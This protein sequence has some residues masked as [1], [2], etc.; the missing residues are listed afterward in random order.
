MTETAPVTESQAAA[1]EVLK[2]A[3]VRE[4]VDALF[5]AV[6]GAGTD[7]AKTT[8]DS[9]TDT[10]PLPADLLESLYANNALAQLIVDSLPDDSLREGFLLKREDSTPDADKDDAEAILKEWSRLQANESRFARGA[11]WGR[12]FGGGGLIL[13]VRGAGDL[14]TPLDDADVTEIEWVKDF[15]RQQVTLLETT[16]TGEP[17]KFQYRPTAHNSS[18]PAV[19]VHASRIIFFPGATTTTQGRIRNQGWDYSVLQAC[20]APLLSYESMWANIDAMLSDSS[21]A[22]F[23]ISGLIQALA[24]DGGQGSV[25]TRLQLMDMSRSNYKAV[26][27]DAGDRQGNGREDFDVVERAG[28]GGLDKVQ[29]N[30][31][32]RVAAAAKTPE[33]ILL[34]TAPGG[35]SATGDLERA[36]HYGR[37]DAYRR[38]VLTPRAQRIVHLIART[39]GQAKPETWEIVWPELEK[40][41]PVDTST[42]V[43]M[44]VDAAVALI[45]AQ[46]LLPEEVALSLARILPDLPITID[47]ASRREALSLGLE[48]LAAR[49]LSEVEGQVPGETTSGRKAAASTSGGSVQG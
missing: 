13:G 19:E 10:P 12:L 34:G 7:R 29:Q 21:Q 9:W 41:S 28:L 31:F 2:R 8:Y 27:L 37:C 24:E 22:V 38:T 17:V 44:A 45:G 4:A 18:A 32:T 16:E 3:T 46:V 49:E 42:R 11:K 23:R 47:L 25:R 26:V 35:D 15:D 6:T 30:Y 39:L 5:N 36:M 43:K 33:S 14:D 1:A 20:Y 48:T 40:S